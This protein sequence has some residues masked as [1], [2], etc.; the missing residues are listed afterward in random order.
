LISHKIIQAVL[1]SA[2]YFCPLFSEPMDNRNTK[3][4]LLFQPK[5]LLSKRPVLE[6]RQWIKTPTGV[7]SG[8]QPLTRQQLKI[9]FPSVS[10]EGFKAILAFSKPELQKVEAA[11]H[12]QSAYHSN[13]AE[14]NAMQK[15]AMVRHLQSLLMGL[16]Q[17]NKTVE[18]YHQVNGV[19][20]SSVQTVKCVLYA[21]PVE[22]AFHVLI[23]G[24]R[25]LLDIYVVKGKERMHYNE[26]KRVHFLLEVDSCYYQLS[27]KSYEAAEWL[28]QQDETKWTTN[29]PA[30]FE[31]VISK[32]KEWELKVDASAITAGEELIAEPQPQVMLSELNNTFLKLEPRFVYDGYTVDGPFEAVTKQQSA[33]KTISIVR[34]QQKEEELVEFLRSLH[35]KFTNQTNGFFYL[36]FA[37]AQKKGWFLKVY[38]R[39]LEM[40]IDLL[41]IDLMKHFRYSQYI[42]E[43]IIS[44][45]EV[46]GNSICLLLTV[47]FGKE[48]IPLTYLQKSLLNGQKA[49]MLK[50]GSLGVL[51]E[52]WLKQYGLLIR[53]GKIRKEELLVPKWLL[54]S[55][56]TETKTDEVRSAVIKTDISAAWFS[57]WKQWEK[58]T[59][60]LYPLPAGLALEQLRPYQQKGYEWLRLLSEIGGS[61]C[62]ADDMGLGKTIQTISFLLHQI[63]E[64]PF[65]KHLVVAPASLLYNWQEELKKFAP[66]VKAIVFHGAERDEEE[67]QHPDHQIVITSYGTLRQDIERLQLLQ[68]NTVVVDESQHIKNPAAQVTKAVWQLLA[69]TRIALSGTPVMNGTGDLYSQMHFLLPGLLGTGEFF[70]RE[71]AIPIEQKAD[72]EKAAALQKLIKPFVLRRTKEQAAPDLPAKTESVLWCEMDTDQRA[73]YESIKENVRSNVLLEINEHGLN[74]GKM[75]VLAGLMKLRQVCNSSE[76]VKDEDIFT[77]ESIKT[78]LLVDELKTIIPQHRALVFSQFTSMLDLLERDLQK[79]GIKTIRLDGQ[80]KVSQRQELVAEFQQEE[81]EVAVFLLSLKAGNAGLN[82]TAADY[83][84]LFDPWWNTAVESQAID[85]THR[86]GQ[87]SHVFAYRMICKNSVEEKIM[88]MAAGKKKIAED[89]I[90]AEEG[91][92][93]SLTLDDIRYLLE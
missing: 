62:L 32:L 59:E 69:K 11:L 42:A 25:Y 71:Y 16:R 14:R 33:D 21:Y 38:H 70:R 40:G 84:F 74:K 44:K 54:M 75:S 57:K 10:D 9:S 83:V 55:E 81:S 41:G 19:S 4:Y 78:K 12:H 36:N 93:K 28:Q 24:N 87:Q 76:L 15:K 68:W 58:Q 7:T 1:S 64:N 72:E 86:I 39:L 90:T 63:E 43:T 3:T 27:S 48:I 29:D 20:A 23:D 53:H 13:E 50:D 88:K 92:V 8:E 77:Y 45:Q 31:Q 18:L 66:S 30:S 52:D 49:V 82:L 34:H 2:A 85:R 17:Q 80:T 47:K 22:L 65:E 37:E 35:E 56:A 51:G 46:D 60:P 73:A 91:F 6:I 61:G 5:H 67:L 26:F 79:E 89:L